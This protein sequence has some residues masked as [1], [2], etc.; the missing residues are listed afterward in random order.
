MAWKNSVYAVVGLVSAVAVLTNPFMANPRGWLIFYVILGG[1]CALLELVAL[2]SKKRGNLDIL[3]AALVMFVVGLLAY[4]SKVTTDPFMPIEGVSYSK[5]AFFGFLSAL[6][7][8]IGSVV[9][10]FFAGI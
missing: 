5:Y 1:L 10:S 2:L 3:L 8:F 6:Y 7:L 4:I 9:K